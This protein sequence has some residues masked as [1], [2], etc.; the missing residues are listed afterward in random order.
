[1]PE[2][3]CWFAAFSDVPCEGALRRCHLFPQHRLRQEYPEGAIWLRD[4]PRAL[5]ARSWRR[6]AFSTAPDAAVVVRTVSLEELQ[7]DP[8]LWVPGC[9]GVVGVSGHHGMFD[10][11]KLV[12]PREKIPV[13]CVAFVE[14][15]RLGA[16]LELDRRYQQTS[17]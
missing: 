3:V 2:P 10:G 9:G 16:F 14:E 1:M 17:D 5:S 8:R 12:V 7:R 15:L 11:Y 4:R 13:E 6:D